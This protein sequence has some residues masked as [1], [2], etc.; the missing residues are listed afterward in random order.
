[1]NY[2][3]SVIL[4][5]VFFP[6]KSCASIT[7]LTLSIWYPCEKRTRTSTTQTLIRAI[8]D[9]INNTQYSDQRYHSCPTMIHRSSV[10]FS[11]RIFGPFNFQPMVMV[12]EVWTNEAKKFCRYFQVS[13]KPHQLISSIHYHRRALNSHFY[14]HKKK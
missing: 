4:V 5:Y 6:S 10:I 1:M 3:C 2:L 8:W 11:R 7:E 12:V 14:Q 9:I 13:D